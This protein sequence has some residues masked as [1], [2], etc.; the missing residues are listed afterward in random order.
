MK[1]GIIV[2][3]CYGQE[4]NTQPWIEDWNKR[5]PV[6]KIKVIDLRTDKE[7]GGFIIHESP[8]AKVEIKRISDDTARIEIKEFISPTVIKRFN[9]EGSLLQKTIEDFRSMIDFVL[10]DPN[11]DGKV[12]KSVYV[13]IPK[14][15]Q[16][17]IKG[18]YEIK[19]LPGKTTVAIK[20]V[21]VL[22]D[23]ILIVNEI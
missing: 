9:L 21:D 1:K 18:K 8:Q 23:E 6:N 13:D 16:E 11:Y 2:I 3:V 20:I 19:V 12:F 15:K 17:L 7:K 22:G 14:K 4:L 10:I 5:T